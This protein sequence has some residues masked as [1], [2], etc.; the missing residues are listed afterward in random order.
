MEIDA[1]GHIK[2]FDAQDGRHYDGVSLQTRMRTLDLLM[3]LR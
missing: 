1:S 3:H 2:A